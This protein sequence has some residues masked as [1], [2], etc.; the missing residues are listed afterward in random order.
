MVKQEKLID[1][2]ENQLRELAIKRNIELGEM[3][4]G[5]MD[6]DDFM[7]ELLRARQLGMFLRDREMSRRI[8]SGQ[9][10][11]IATV[12]TD[13]KE[14]RRQYMEISMPQVFKEITK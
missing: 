13:D 8:E 11:R 3:K 7:K 5:D 6:R 4:L 9:I 1:N 14:Q 12:I 2:R 10:I